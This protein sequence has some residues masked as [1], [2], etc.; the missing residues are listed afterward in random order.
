MKYNSYKDS[1]IVWLGNIPTH[2][3]SLRVKD[4]GDIINGYAFSS[5]DFTNKGVR[6]LKIA[7]IQHMKI[8]FTDESYV[9]QDLYDTLK[10]FRIH[11]GD[12]VFALTRP[13]ISTGIKAAIVNS[14]DKLLLNQRN[15]VFR[16]SK[17]V[18]KD[19]F[20]Y[21]LL[22]NSFIEIFDNYIDKTGTQPNISATKIGWINCQYPNLL[23]QTAIAEY[24]DTKTQAIDKK[25]SLLQ[26][27][28]GYYQELRKSLIN[29][30]VTQGLNKSVTLEQN[31]LGFKTPSSWL[32]YR[33]KD[34][35]KLFS[36]LSGKSGDDFN[37]DNNPDNKGFIPFTNIANNTYLKKDHL[38]TVV[39]AEGERQNKVRKG[40]IFFLM[41]LRA[42]KILARQQH[43]QRILK[44]HTSIVFAKD[45]G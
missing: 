19:W 11:S 41:S 25:V 27:K 6:V 14:S 40:D 23:E 24:L 9:K 32:K 12:I 39:V 16:P 13:I 37:Q 20:Y 30:T 38:G 2:W 21:L 36:G 22:S 4:L 10:Q 28:I 3:E 1:G 35:G 5:Y 43:W 44:K 42:M 26:K 33:L 34:F 8:D 31:E 17:R 29:D 7:N 18:N 45:T 15:A